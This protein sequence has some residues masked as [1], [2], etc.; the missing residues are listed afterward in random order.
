MDTSYVVNPLY[1]I[2]FSFPHQVLLS[3]SRKSQLCNFHIPS[4]I[5][6]VAQ[7]VARTLSMGKV[8]GSIP[9]SSIIFLY[10]KQVISS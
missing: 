2:A 7:L 1:I 10:L 9:D 3:P 5:G 8:S 6:R 4:E